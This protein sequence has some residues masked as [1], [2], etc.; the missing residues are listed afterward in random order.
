MVIT[1]KQKQVVSTIIAA[2]A[3]LTLAWVNCQPEKPIGTLDQTPLGTREGDR[4][5]ELVA[6]APGSFYDVPSLYGKAQA[7]AIKTWT[8]NEVLKA[9]DLNNNFNHLHNTMVGGHGARLVDADVSTLA[10]ISHTKLATPALVPKAWAVLTTVCDGAAA[11]GTACTV[12]ES[13]QVTAVKSNGT[14]GQYRVDLSYSPPNASFAV[15]V[16]AISD[17]IYCVAYNFV[18]TTGDANGTNFVVDCETDASVATNSA[19]SFVL[20]DT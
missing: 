8:V 14:A 3:A 18:A 6:W 16:T 15:L 4:C 20:L 11:A 10:A 1:A 7:S 5:E 19:F 12:N 2:L 13:S 9:T 17:D